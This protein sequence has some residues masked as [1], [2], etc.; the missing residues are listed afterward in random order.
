[1]QWLQQ[2]LPPMRLAVNVSVRQLQQPGFADEV[3]EALQD[4]GL[5]A[6]LLE[7]EIT[8]STLQSVPQ[9]RE[10]LGR[11]KALGVSVAI[12]DFGTGFSSL[13]LLKHLA[14][15]RLKLDRSFVQDLPSHGPNV[16]VTRAI[17]DLARA[18]HLALTAE[19][20][21]TQAQRS[22]LLGMGCQEGQGYLF[23]RPMPAEELPAL[24][25][26]APSLNLPD[27]D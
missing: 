11:L 10:M 1:V 23:A 9:S 22:M 6:H 4:S 14:I 16:Q 25:R 13:S 27:A 15:D 21:E 24:L 7:L 19:G 3:A 18:L 2:G 8:E 26:G 12:D 20:I 17:V 5:P